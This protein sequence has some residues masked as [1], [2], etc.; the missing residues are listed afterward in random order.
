MPRPVR[1]LYPRWLPATFFAVLI[2]TLSAA[3]VR[4]AGDAPHARAPHARECDQQHTEACRRAVA[5]WRHRAARAEAAV[6]WQRRARATEVRHVLERVRGAQPFAYSARLAYAACLSFE[7]D[8]KRCKPPGEMLSVGR[9]ESGLKIHNP[10]PSS[11]ADNWLQYLTST[12]ASTVVA[13]L[14]W[15]SRYDPMAVAIAAESASRTGWDAW[16]ASI[17]CHGLS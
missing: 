15:F 16:R 1:R 8:P 6:T 17:H 2:L 9:C 7:R 3:T 13:K 4:S 5:Y 14:G 12:W 11:T 10:N